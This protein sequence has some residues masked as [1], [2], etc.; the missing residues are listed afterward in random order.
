VRNPLILFL[1]DPTDGGDVPLSAAQ[2]AVD[3]ICVLQAIGTAL[4]STLQPRL[5]SIIPNLLVAL[6]SSI[7]LVRHITAVTYAAL[8]RS[9]PLP[10]LM[11][12]VERA[13]PLLGDVT[14]SKHRQG[15]IEVIHRK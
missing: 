11:A 2:E 9:I 12:V 7:P 14:N 15:A 1:C 6:K 4:P 10:G 5:E 3:C 13:V 8:C